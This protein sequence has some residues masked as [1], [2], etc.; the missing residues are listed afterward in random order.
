MIGLVEPLAP[1][2]HELKKSNPRS[3]RELITSV[4]ASRLT[5]WQQCRLKFWFRY[6]AG[7]VKAPGAALH[8]GSTVHAVLQQWNLGRWR[9]TPLDA[10]ALKAVF[11]QAWT[12]QEDIEW[13]DTEAACRTSAWNVL[14][15]Y[16]QQ[17]PI[18]ADERPE[19][20]E[21]G[22]EADLSQHGLPRLVGV[23]DLVR[24]GG[25]IVDFKT[26]AR[27][28][29]PAMVAH[30]TEIQ[31]T[32]YG[33][34]Y[35]EATGNR[36]SGIELHHM[37]KTKTPKLVVTEL[38]AASEQQATRL[39]HVMEDYVQGLERGAFIPSPGLQCASCEFFGECR[40]WS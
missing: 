22:V 15:T 1:S 10:P 24:A 11:D 18:P 28:P 32:C 34:L 37:V 3:I 13:E 38:G 29:D 27:T 9:K 21:V 35:R 30:T 40:A 20:V 36:E 5:T 25:R 14:E 6:V 33:L 23:L 31:T 7:L 26:T 19:G 17:T 39:F 4:S 12:E 8:F 16:F 2:T